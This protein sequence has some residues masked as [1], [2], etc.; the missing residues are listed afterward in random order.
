MQ[1]CLIS[2]RSQHAEL[3]VHCLMLP[4]GES[5]VD[6]GVA[7]YEDCGGLFMPILP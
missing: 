3:K 2:L 1:L 7:L 4:H 5:L 6:T